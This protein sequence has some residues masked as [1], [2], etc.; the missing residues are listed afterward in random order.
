GSLPALSILLSLLGGSLGRASIESGHSSVGTRIGDAEF[1]NSQGDVGKLS[2]WRES[3]L[4]VAIFFGADCP[5]AKL[6]APRLGELCREFGPKGVAFVGINPNRHEDS[7]AIARYVRQHQPTSPLS[8]CSR[9]NGRLSLT[10]ATATCR[11]RAGN[12]TAFTLAI[13]PFCCR[14]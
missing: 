4:V 14:A 3:P 7:A 1:V 11:S 5:V 10:R 6:Y 12:W 2:D 8:P 9:T 13:T